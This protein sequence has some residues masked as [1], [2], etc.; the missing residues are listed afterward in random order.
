MGTE[1]LQVAEELIN[2][3][4]RDCLGVEISAALAR[5]HRLRDTPATRCGVETA[6]IDLMAQHAGLPVAVWLNR[7]AQDSVSVNAV[8]GAVDDRLESRAW[9]ATEEGFSLIKVKIGLQPIAVERQALNAL[10]RILPEGTMLR[11]DANGCW[12]MNQASEAMSVLRNLPVESLE[13]PLLS[14]QTESLK[15]LQALVPWPLALDESLRRWPLENL[16]VQTPVRRLVLKPMLLGGLLPSYQLASQAQ[17]VGIESVVTTTVD[18]AAGVWAALHLAAALNNSL[19]HG[20]NTGTWLKEDIGDGPR[21][22]L[23]K[24]TINHTPGLGFA[25]YPEGCD[26][27]APGNLY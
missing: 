18:S 22:K 5:L 6:L 7:N 9:R 11:L 19:T 4:L 3:E 13:E 2:I 14:P 27:S 20:L 10:T 21:L 15:S 1:T 25:P 16:L 26:F 24:M 23:D 12:D 8:L 17:Q